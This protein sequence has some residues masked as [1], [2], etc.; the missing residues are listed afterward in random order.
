MSCL[1]TGATGFL[2]R[3]LCMAL[4]E[5]GHSVVAGLR[6]E[7]EGPWDRVVLFDLAKGPVPSS[8]LQGVSC[9]FHLAGKAHALSETVQDNRDYIEI[10][11]TG[12]RRLLDASRA[13]GVERLVFFSSVKAMVEDTVQ[14]LDETAECHPE[15]PYGASKLE[16]ERLVLEGGFVSEPVV[17]R[18]SMVYGP[19]HKG[20]FARMIEA[21]DK[22]RFPPLPELGN[23]RS[24]VCV[25]DVVQAA[26]LAMQSPQAT[27]QIYIVTDGNCYS[28]RQIYLGIRAALG[29]QP[30]SWT[31]PVALLNAFARFGDIVGQIRGKRFIFDSDAMDKLT[32][33]ACFSSGKIERELGFRPKYDLPSALPEIVACLRSEQYSG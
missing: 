16:A 1:V 20:N 13:A 14:I 10:N 33:S 32:G 24:M 27:G 7:A 28:T 18:L 6:A 2:G 26:I 30:P 9:V 12:T 11:T 5:H 19:T 15:T 8:E 17:L 29:R 3:H 31:I 25:H 22:G 21:V 4:K 23:R